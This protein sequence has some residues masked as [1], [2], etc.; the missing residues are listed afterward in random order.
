MEGKAIAW[1]SLREHRG[2]RHEWTIR[3][4]RSRS[5]VR[6]EHGWQE[7]NPWQQGKMQLRVDGVGVRVKGEP[8][9]SPS[10][11]QSFWHALPHKPG[12]WR[13]FCTSTRPGRQQNWKRLREEQVQ[14]DCPC[15]HVWIPLIQQV[16]KIHRQDYLVGNRL[17]KA[18]ISLVELL[19]RM[20]E[21]DSSAIASFPQ[22]RWPI[23][24]CKEGIPTCPISESCIWSLE[25]WCSDPP[26]CP[27]LFLPP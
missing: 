4:A 6:W 23:S 25:W 10:S 5:W 20:E 8:G 2:K 27:S 17:S 16:L 3:A 1:G 19:Y 18:D 12:P 13:E 15:D 9:L 14:S 22:L 11:L 24:Q 26:P 7:L 21:I